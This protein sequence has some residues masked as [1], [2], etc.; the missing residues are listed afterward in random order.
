MKNKNKGLREFTIDY[1]RWGQE[2]LL[3]DGKMCCLGFCAKAIGFKNY[4]LVD[5]GLL[6]DLRM[7]LA[8]FQRIP[9]FLGLPAADPSG[10]KLLIGNGH[11]TTFQAYLACVNDSGLPDELKMAIITKIFGRHGI[12]VSWKNVPKEIS[13]EFDR[14]MKN[15]RAFSRAKAGIDIESV[16]K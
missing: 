6:Y 7:D 4:Q 12:R 13:S 11:E 14:M 16:L 9:D 3:Q 15:S 5:A 10:K 1:K 2:S 8:A